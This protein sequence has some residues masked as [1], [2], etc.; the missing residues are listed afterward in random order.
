MLGVPQWFP[1]LSDSSSLPP[2][3]R[4]LSGVGPP[5]P[6]LTLGPPQGGRSLSALTPLSPPPSSS[7][8]PPGP[9]ANK[10][11]PACTGPAGGGPQAVGVAQAAVTTAAQ[12]ATGQQPKVVGHVTSQM[13]VNQARNAVRSGRLP[14][15]M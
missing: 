9:D 10:P 11:L 1:W 7:S 6:P 13:T 12:T 5:K 15:V 2:P 8:L 4:T 14:G 3:T